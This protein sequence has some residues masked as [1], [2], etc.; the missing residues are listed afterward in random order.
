MSCLFAKTNEV[1]SQCE[2]LI[3]YPDWRRECT[4]VHFEFLIK[5]LFMSSNK[6]NFFFAGFPKSGSTLFWHML[7]EH[8]EIHSSPLKELNYFNT[9]HIS[10]IKQKLGKNLPQQVASEADY[11]SLYVHPNSNF[12]GDFNPTYIYSEDAPK[13]IYDYNKNAKIIISIREPVSYL[14]STHFQNLYNLAEDETEF[15]KALSLE[16]LR[17]QGTNIPQTCVLPFFLYYSELIQYQKFIRR[18][19]EQFPPEQIKVILFDH[20][21]T[22]KMLVYQSLLTFLCVEDIDFRTPEPDR[23]PSHRLRFKFARKILLNPTINKAL[24]TII[25]KK[26]MPLGVKISHKL[27]KKEDKKPPLSSEDVNKL[28]TQFRAEVQLLSDYLCEEGLIDVDLIK[29]WGY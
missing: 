25:P 27:F 19:V 16:S 28:K 12:N 6:V 4:I 1:K 13:N 8:P 29:L 10:V 3:T 7:T 20:I 5:A 18:Y 11:Q 21:I 17:K 26:M 9:D 24:L 23:N 2:V 15:L 14:R 22:D